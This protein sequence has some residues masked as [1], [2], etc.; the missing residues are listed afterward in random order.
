M[1]ECDIEVPAEWP[2]SE[3]ARKAS[4]RT[5]YEYF[6]E[7]S[8]LFATTDVS[9]ESIGPHMQ[10]YLQQCGGST[11]S[12]RLL[13]GGMRGKHLLLA[14]PLVMWY[15]THGLVVTKVYE[16]I[17]YTPK[18]CFKP[19]TRQVTLERREGDAMLAN[20]AKLIGNSSYGSL[21]IDKSKHSK[22]VYVSGRHDACLKVND[23]R[24]KSLTELDDDH[25]EV[26]MSK[27][28]IKMDMPIQLGYFILQYAKLRMLQFYYD[29]I[30]RFCDRVDYEYLEMDTDS[31]YM[32]LSAP[33]LI[34]IVKPE[35]RE[36]FLKQLEN[37]CTDKSMDARD[38]WFPRTCCK[39]HAKFDNREPGLFK[40]EFSGD[41]MI[42]LCSKTYVV[43]NAVET[44]FSC[45][46]IQK[47]HVIDPL[48]I[49]NTVLNTRITQSRTNIG[50]RSKDNKISTYTQQRGGF[51]YFYIKRQVA[52]DGIHTKPLDITLCPPVV[53]LCPSLINS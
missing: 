13:I 45:K 40:L 19:F 53:T 11:K 27:R 15:L 17:E 10:E 7:F 51:S 20:V 29:C 14:S 39:K 25:Y 1:I 26:V 49:F 41:E 43:S 32:G 47:R 12:R 31:A 46:G 36:E 8:P 21:L 16:A 35:M 6:E 37:H 42:C 28:R 24:F 4:G 9:F 30:D 23:P 2:S 50:F 34:D 52:A 3:L 44:K 33:R 22:I 5:P 48:A 38:Y 18:A